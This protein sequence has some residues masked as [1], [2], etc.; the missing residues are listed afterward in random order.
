MFGIIYM[1]NILMKTLVWAI[2]IFVVFIFVRVFFNNTP[3]PDAKV[4]QEE[5]S[6]PIPFYPCLEGKCP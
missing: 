5:V 4:F 1:M 3:V 6:E 2:V